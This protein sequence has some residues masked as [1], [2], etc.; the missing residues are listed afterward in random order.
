MTAKLTTDQGEKGRPTC[1]TISAGVKAVLIDLDETLYQ[2]GASLIRA[3][4]LRITAFIALQSGISWEKADELRQRLWREYGTTARGLNLLYDVSERELNRF[5]VDSVDPAQ[6]LHVDPELD[7]CLAQIPAP[8][9]VFTNATRR[10]TERVLDALGVRRR[11]SGIFDI[12]FGLYHPKP[13]PLFYQR[14]ITYL[15]FPPTQIVLVDDNLRNLGPALEL[16][17]RCIYV[18]RKEEAEGV[19]HATTLAQVP[20]LL[21]SGIV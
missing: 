17:M 16:G 15:T 4:D 2:P 13:S 14:V 7:Q 18:G 20:V 21:R 8:C 19:M 5:A 1:R 12:A 11:F 3:I 10:Y 9:Y 6:Y